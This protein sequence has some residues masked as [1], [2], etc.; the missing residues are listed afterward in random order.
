MSLSTNVVPSIVRQ[1][2]EEIELNG[3][4]M[5]GIYRVSGVKSKVE[6]LCHSYE[7][8]PQSV[9]LSNLSPNIIANVLK[10][11]FREVYNEILNI[12]DYDY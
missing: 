1:C 5:N 10:H 7:T 11:F 12:I 8:N 4:H 3:V 9:E 2:V 6:A